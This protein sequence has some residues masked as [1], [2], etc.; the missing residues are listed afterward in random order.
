MQHSHESRTEIGL[1]PKDVA[2]G[3][4]PTVTKGGAIDRLGFEE[5]RVVLQ[6]GAVEAGAALDCKVQE[7]D[8]TTDGDFVDVEDAAFV[9]VAGGAGVLSGIFEGRLNLVGR[10]R[11]LRVV[12]TVTGQDKKACH[13]A[14]VI[15]TMA[16]EKPVA[17]VNALAFSV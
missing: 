9:Q 7:S 5:A 1:N 11:Y 14:N 8:T 12:S 16:K 10:K 4:T 13:S 3:A 2:G 17:P 15:L 6:H